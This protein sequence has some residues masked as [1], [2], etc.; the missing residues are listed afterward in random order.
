[1]LPVRELLA[2]IAAKTIRY[3][4]FRAQYLNAYWNLTRN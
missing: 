1:M 3:S 4:D 2:F